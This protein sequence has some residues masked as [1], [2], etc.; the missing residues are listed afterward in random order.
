MAGRYLGDQEIDDD[1][2]LRRQQRAKPGLS[3]AQLGDVG[4]DEAVEEVAGVLAGDLDYAPI[5]K[6][7]CFHSQNWLF[8]QVPWETRRPRYPLPS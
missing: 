5:W 6:K 7:R 1:L 3:R 8:F 4:G 2:A